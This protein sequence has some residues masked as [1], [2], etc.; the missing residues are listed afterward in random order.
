MKYEGL[1]MLGRG[2]DLA[3]LGPTMEEWR[4]L[5][6]YK[7]LGG[8]LLTHSY[9]IVLKTSCVRLMKHLMSKWKDIAG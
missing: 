2:Y 5:I 4:Y 8:L 9:H 1:L 7:L 6:C 3:S